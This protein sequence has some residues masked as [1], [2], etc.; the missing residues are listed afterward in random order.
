[1]VCT[2]RLPKRAVCYFVKYLKL[3]V[4]IFWIFAN[5]QFLFHILV[6]KNLKRITAL[7]ICIKMSEQI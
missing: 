4:Y 5:L 3:A 2:N 1:M 7:T 6:Y